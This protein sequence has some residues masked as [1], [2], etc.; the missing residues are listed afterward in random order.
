MTSILITLSFL[1]C[2]SSGAMLSMLI[3]LVAAYVSAS[4]WL[5]SHGVIYTG[6]LYVLVY[7]GA[8]VV[9]IMFVVQLTNTSLSGD[10]NTLSTP[11]IL[12]QNSVLIISLVILLTGGYD[13]L[14]SNLLLNL[15]NFNLNV[16]NFDLNVNLTSTLISSLDNHTHGNQ[17]S[18]LAN[19]IFNEYGYILIIS[20][21]AII[22]AVIGPIKL[23][24][25]DYRSR[26]PDST[27]VGVG[28]NDSPL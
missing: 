21:H 19:Q 20:I 26:S 25:S 13:I 22:L 16:V 1:G 4:I 12:L 10:N 6:L 11:L 24:L 17:L 28:G 14:N 5:I 2:V 9:L 27:Q 7:V 3:L 18:I 23:A 15:S 8:I